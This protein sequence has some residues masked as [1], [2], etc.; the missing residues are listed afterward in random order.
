MPKTNA[1]ICREY[2]RRQK[3]A[4]KNKMVT[5]TERVRNFRRRQKALRYKLGFQD[6]DSGQS[7]CVIILILIVKIY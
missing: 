4:G 5:S 7:H 6:T 2:R 3:E 1:E